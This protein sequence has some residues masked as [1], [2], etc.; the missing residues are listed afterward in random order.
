MYPHMNKII[1]FKHMWRTTGV[2]PFTV[3]VNINNGVNAT[4]TETTYTF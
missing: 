1:I 3:I 4:Y 2:K